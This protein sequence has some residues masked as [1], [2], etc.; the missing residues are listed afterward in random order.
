MR[1]IPPLNSVR[2][3]EAAARHESF[4][5]AAEELCVTPPAISQQVKQ[6]EDWLGR[7]LFRRLNRGLV[8]T[9]AG[10][11]YLHSLTDLLD[12]LESATSFVL[13]VPESSILTVGVT[14]GFAALWLGPRL[15]SFATSHPELDI[16]VSASVHPLGGERRNIDV[17]IPYGEGNYRGYT[18]ELLLKD[19]LT[20]VCA[21]SLLN[22]PHPLRT[23]EDLSRHTLLHNESAVVAGF[24]ATWQDWLDAVGGHR[25]DPHR[26]LHFSDLHLV[27]QE[28]IAGRGVGLGHLALI[29]E[30]LRSGRL[31]RPFEE[32]LPAR[33]DFHVVYQPDAERASRVEAFLDW[34]R[35]QA[36]EDHTPWGRPQPAA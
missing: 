27:M 16:R 31:V 7:K 12:R 30:E 10:Q 25:V 1:K 11:T 19:G 32:V 15:W 36:A 21:P 29:G 13:G 24:N 2:A 34:L 22:G 28:A 33:G 14:P 35:Q 6:L 20:P 18:C 3:F 8:L 9:P 17:A 26:G 23:P 5:K 4:I